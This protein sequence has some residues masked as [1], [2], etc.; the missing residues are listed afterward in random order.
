MLHYV[1]AGIEVQNPEALLELER[2][3]LRR[4]MGQYNQGLVSQAGLAE[5]LMSQTRA[6]ENE[7][8]ALQIRITANIRQ[9]NRAEAGR[10][11]LRLREAGAD[12]AACRE[13]LAQTEKTY[14]SLKQA[15]ELAIGMAKAK[16]ESVRRAIGELRTQRAVAELS[17]LA[18]GLTTGSA[19]SGETLERLREMVDEQRSHAAG[20]ARVARDALG[21]DDLQARETEHAALAEQA[22]ADFLAQSADFTTANQGLMQTERPV[23]SRAL[24]RAPASGPT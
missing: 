7:Q 6:L 8:T 22:L 18:A 17:S 9:G 5:R 20:R 1:V 11:A 10:A 19:G 4:L 2:E 12:L 24:I 16:I 13:Q 23:G 14:E 15:R 3:N 21:L